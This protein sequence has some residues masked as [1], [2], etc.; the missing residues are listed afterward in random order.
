MQGISVYERNGDKRLVYHTFHE[1]NGAY[2]ERE[3]ESETFMVLTDVDDCDPSSFYTV[4]SFVALIAD[5]E[6]V[7]R[8]ASSQG[9]YELQNH[10]TEI[11]VLCRFCLWNVGQFT[12]VISPFEYVP[13]EE[14]P[15]ELPEN[16][17]KGLSALLLP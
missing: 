16:Y 14:I 12:L 17:K 3:N 5:L 2:L 6:Q 1:K 13:F 9:D 8:E 10:L 15:S 4:E 11:L 7:I